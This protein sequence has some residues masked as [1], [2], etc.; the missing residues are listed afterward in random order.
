VTRSALGVCIIIPFLLLVG[1]YRFP[2]ELARREGV[3]LEMLSLTFLLILMWTGSAYFFGLYMFGWIFSVHCVLMS[4]AFL[5][6]YIHHQYEDA[7]W[8]RRDE[9]DFIRAGLEGSGFLDVS[10][11]LHWCTG[12]IGY[13][14]V[15]HL[16]TSIPN[17]E[18]SQAHDWCMSQ[19]YTVTP[20][21]LWEIPRSFHCSLWDIQ[22]KKLISFYEIRD[23]NRPNLDIEQ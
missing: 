7:Y 3:H 21:T 13:H 17:Y 8:A 15:H 2:N 16:C 11:L 1:L 14:H 10:P 5:F 19:G 23:S 4:T 18:L 9:F 20:M 22:K 6:F 12:S